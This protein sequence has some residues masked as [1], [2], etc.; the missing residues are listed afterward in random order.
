[1]I[2]QNR[3]P[4]L[5]TPRLILRQMDL[6][7]LDF[8]FRHFG[9]PEVNRY[10]VDEPPI[11]TREQAEEIIR[12]YLHPQGKS[13]NRWG[14]ALKE[15]G[16]LIGTV[17]YH[18]WERKHYRAEIGYDLSRKYWR[19]GL[20]SE[21]LGVALDFG[22]ESMALHRVGA[23]VH[24]DNRASIGLLEKF[25]FAREGKL[26]GYYHREDEFVD[27]LVFSLLKGSNSQYERWGEAFAE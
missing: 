7:D 9:D 16:A 26:R 25:G 27:H 23:L 4:T 19:R 3:M 22:F 5:S 21:A 2:D 1:M 17:G 20:M 11:T 14:I 6:D 13:Y 18:Q 10:L 24:P 12:F 8:A 15:N